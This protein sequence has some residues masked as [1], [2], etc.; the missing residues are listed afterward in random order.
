M[1]PLQRMEHQ[2]PSQLRHTKNSEHRRRTQPAETHTSLP[3]PAIGDQP[4]AARWPAAFPLSHR[5]G[6]GVT[7]LG[8][9]T[10]HPGS[11]AQDV[12]PGRLTCHPADA[13]RG[14]NRS[15]GNRC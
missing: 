14:T 5:A 11:L 8:V 7:I 10:S 13:R 3:P 2:H 9:T 1:L 4:R 12:G 6:A 15:R